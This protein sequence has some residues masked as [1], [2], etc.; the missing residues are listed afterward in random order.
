MSDMK[1]LCTSVHAKHGQH[2]RPAS[3]AWER[4]RTRELSSSPACQGRRVVARRG[5]RVSAALQQVQRA[6]VNAS[7]AEEGQFQTALKEWSVACAALGAGE[8][9]VRSWW[10]A[11]KEAASLTSCK[12][13]SQSQ[14]LAT[15]SW[16]TAAAP[17][18]SF[19]VPARMS[20]RCY[21]V[22]C[23]P[24][25]VTV[26]GTGAAEERGHQREGLQAT[27]DTLS[28]DANGLP[29]RRCCAGAW[30]GGK[31]P[32]GEQTHP[33]DSSVCKHSLLPVPALPVQLSLCTRAH[34]HERPLS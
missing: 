15:S 28:A 25:R 13:V 21:V 6:E 10:Q 19:P 4:K 26:L 32:E 5:R 1:A 16:C 3:R 22:Q 7:A 8:Q 12:L 14:W 24:P 23:I 33:C 18:S 30:G 27:V 11:A 2:L 20:W 29:R 17:R 9:T 31:V 34:I